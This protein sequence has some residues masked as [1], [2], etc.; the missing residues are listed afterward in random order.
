[1]GSGKAL[2]QELI[3]EHR[4][5]YH[6]LSDD[7]KDSL[8]REYD[9]HKITKTTG[10][11]ISTKSKINDVTQTLRVIENEVRVF[12]YYFVRQDLLINF[13]QLNSLWSRTGVETILYT[14]RGSTDLPLRGITF[15]TKGVEEF[16]T[17]VM[18][19]DDQD[20]VGKM[21]GFAIRGIRGG[22]FFWYCNIVLIL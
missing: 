20:F 21:E 5:E 22:F 12:I 7:A 1:V 3:H 11:R 10:I 2:L 15:A 13:V 9:E 18:N 16:M 17:S 14:T 19:I 6:A 8:L 4:D